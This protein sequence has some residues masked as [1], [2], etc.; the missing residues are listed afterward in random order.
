MALIKSNPVS[1][2]NVLPGDL[3]R[4]RSALTVPGM[5]SEIAKLLMNAFGRVV[6][7]GNKRVIKL[8]DYSPELIKTLAPEVNESAVFERLQIDADRDLAPLALEYVM[9]LKKLGEIV[10][11]RAGGEDN[12]AAAFKAIFSTEFPRVKS[13]LESAGLTVVKRTKTVSTEQVVFIVTDPANSERVLGGAFNADDMIFQLDETSNKGSTNVI[14]NGHDLAEALLSPRRV[15][16][17]QAPQDTPATQVPEMNPVLHT[18]LFGGN[19]N[20]ADDHDDSTG[21]VPSMVG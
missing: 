14:S 16:T 15:S 8:H 5:P 3:V 9:G 11:N 12:Q 13:L 1:G 10:T 2:S 17:P 6:L 18:I 21:D 4:I 7:Q 19:E 20:G